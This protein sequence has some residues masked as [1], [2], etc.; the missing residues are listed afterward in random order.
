MKFKKLL[1]LA[2]IIPLVTSCQQDHVGIFFYFNTVIDVKLFEGTRD[3]FYNVGHLMEQVDEVS[4]SYRQ[5]S[6]SDVYTINHTNEPVAV[7][8]VL[9][10]LLYQAYYAKEEFGA[11]YYNPLCGSL[12]ELWKD[13]LN[14]DTIPTDEEIEAELTK[15]NNTTLIF[16]MGDS[17]QRVGDATI[18]LG[19]IAK[20]YALNWVRSMLSN[21]NIHKY[22]VNAGSSSILLGENKTNNGYFNVGFKHYITDSYLKLKNCTVSTSSVAEQGKTIGDITYSHIVNPVTGS[23]INNWDC[24]VVISENSYI[25]DA[26]STSMMMNTLEEIQTIEEEQNVM[27]IVIKDDEVKYVN[28]G[29]TIYHY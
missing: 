11:T 23:A 22:I 5:R 14:H 16:S 28:E 26:L 8:D 12:S 29:I 17:I 18:D 2:S 19:G 15:I 10:N 9:Y 7:N 3:S 6:E 13:C 20:G 4:D 27:T 1:L 21:A 24:V 25:G